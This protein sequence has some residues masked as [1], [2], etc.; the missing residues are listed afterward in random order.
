MNPR[1]VSDLLR[2]IW[3][4]PWVR[5]VAY[6]LLVLLA[7][8][9]AR[10]ISGVLVLGLVAYA[11]AYLFNPLLVWLERRRIPRGVGVLLLVLLLGVLAGLLLWGGVAQLQSLLAD[12]PSFVKQLGTLGSDLLERLRGVPGLKDAPERLTAA[13]NA[14]VQTLSTGALPFLQRLLSSGGTLLGGA[15]G[16]VGWLGQTA[17]AL[18]LAVY[19]MLDYPRVGRS[20]LRLLPVGWQSA[21]TRLCG[22]VAE[23]F[24]GY[25]RG[26]LLI[27]LACWSRWV[28]CRSAC[29]TRWAWACCWRR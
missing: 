25:V 11:I 5:L 2:I 29:P 9:L 10:Q 15:F 4:Q 7:L 3:A 16:F 21:A 13:V 19:F 23:S 22:D 20:V 1:S 27:G 12:L 14:Q 26:Q 6:V 18:T 17:F 8:R 28:C 24:G